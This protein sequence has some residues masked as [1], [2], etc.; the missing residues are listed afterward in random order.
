MSEPGP[1]AIGPARRALFER[2]RDQRQTAWV[3]ATGWS[4]TPI[5]NP[6]DWLQ[7]DFGVG[8][9][10]RPGSI[11]LFTIGDDVISH[12]VLWR[13]GGRLVTKGDSTTWL[14]RPVAADQLLGV[15]RAV[16]R[17]PDGEP[18]SS[19]CSGPRATAVTLVSLGTAA[20]A[21]LARPLPPRLRRRALALVER[22]AGS[23]CARLAGGGP[24]A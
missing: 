13:R 9:G 10:V 4:M 23:A 22:V 6:G 5:V 7:V 1:A 12:R 16:R 21:R 2:Y 19:A 24:G 15:V 3:Q 20:T 18:D 17:D 14:D 11:V 8:S